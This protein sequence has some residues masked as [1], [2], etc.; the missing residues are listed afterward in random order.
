MEQGTLS[1]FWFNIFYIL[2]TAQCK[3]TML[4]KNIY[5]IFKKC[6]KM[7]INMHRRHR[8]FLINVNFRI[9]QITLLLNSECKEKDKYWTKCVAMCPGL[10]YINFEKMSTRKFVNFYLKLSILTILLLKKHKHFNNS[11]LRTSGH[12]ALSTF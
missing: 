6:K 9:W 7:C 3:S 11:I 2:F 8:N 1:H 12:I 10:P 4:Y 5:S